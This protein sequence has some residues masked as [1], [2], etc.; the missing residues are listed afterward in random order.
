MTA[1]TTVAADQLAD[2]IAI[3]AA[4]APRDLVPGGPVGVV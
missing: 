3:A 1:G 4:N 2:L